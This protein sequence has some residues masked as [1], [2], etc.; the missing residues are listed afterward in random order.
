MT[1]NCEWLRGLHGRCQGVPRDHA[2]AAVT[3]NAQSPIVECTVRGTISSDVDAK[4][5]RCRHCRKGH[6]NTAACCRLVRR[7][8]SNEE[9]VL[10]LQQQLH[11]KDMK[12]TDIRLEALSSAHQLEQLRDTM[13]QMKVGFRL[14]FS[15]SIFCFVLVD[16]RAPVKRHIIVRKN[17]WCAL[18]ISLL[19]TIFYYTLHRHLVLQCV[20]KKETEIFSVIF[21]IRLGRFWW[22]L[23]HRFPNKFAANR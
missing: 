18:Y 9:S 6:W 15:L 7:P 12:L 21:S 2:R 3:Q 8:V 14:W 16:F 13:N 19:R 11:E 5:N 23:V 22:N 4:R 1:T 10:E 20:Q 17:V